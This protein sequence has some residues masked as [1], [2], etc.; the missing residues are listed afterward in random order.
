MIKNNKVSC[1][2][3]THQGKGEGS[4][5]HN[6]HSWKD[7]SSRDV[8]LANIIDKGNDDFYASE[9]KFY[10]ERYNQQLQLQNEKYIAKRNYSRCKDIIQFYSSK[11]YAPVEKIL[12]YGNCTIDRKFKP[13]RYEFENIVETYLERLSKWSEEHGNHLH[14]LNCAIHLDGDGADDKGEVSNHAQLRFIW[15]YVD[16]NGVIQCS[17]EEAMKRAGIELPDSSKPE[18]RFNNRN[19]TF[20]NM[21]RDM[22]NDVCEEYGFPVIREPDESRIKVHQEVTTYKGQTALELQAKED[23]LNIDRVAFEEYKQQEFAKLDAERIDAE[24]EINAAVEVN[25]RLFETKRK[26]DAEIKSKSAE[27]QQ[28]NAE[29]EKGKRNPYFHGS[30]KVVKKV[31]NDGNRISEV[32]DI[33][34]SGF[35]Q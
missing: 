19:I 9:I 1:R 32:K 14:L 33:E 12:Q 8:R 21:T 6:T 18:G 13:D 30:G 22:W 7:E 35:D 23:A 2:T 4:A 16:E 28:V 15:D 26:L 31:V 34:D 5:K 3:T 29:I 17:Q 27:L 10:E 11:R 20:T 25:S 24:T